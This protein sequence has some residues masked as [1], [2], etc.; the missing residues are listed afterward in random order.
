MVPSP[1]Q[2]IGLS[3]LMM[4]CASGRTDVVQELTRAG[5]NVNIQAEVRNT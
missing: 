4:A 3:A 1:V 2:D 5:A